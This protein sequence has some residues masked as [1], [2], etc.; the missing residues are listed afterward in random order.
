M[1]TFIDF[2]DLTTEIARQ[3]VRHVGQAEE[4]LR[5]QREDKTLQRFV[6]LFVASSFL[7]SCSSRDT[8]SKFIR[9]AGD[10]NLRIT[11]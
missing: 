4:A 11:T 2:K 3:K 5:T 8:Y 7:L 9:N 10:G 6:A 1:N